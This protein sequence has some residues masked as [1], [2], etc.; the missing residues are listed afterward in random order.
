[1][2]EFESIGTMHCRVLVDKID[3][4]FVPDSNHSL[5][6]SGRSYAVF[7]AVTLPTNDDNGEALA[8]PLQNSNSRG[9]FVD[10]AVPINVS[11]PDEMRDV[12]Q[13]VLQAAQNATKVALRVKS[14]AGP[15]D[16]ELVGVTFPA[17]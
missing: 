5:E 1:M 12:L 17:R 10:E 4:F 6:C 11:K 8:V 7:V 3:L 14:K 9:I 13:V 2:S 16:V 15:S